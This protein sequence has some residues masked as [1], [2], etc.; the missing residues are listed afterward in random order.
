VQSPLEWE[1]LYVLPNLALPSDPN[2]GD[3][4]DWPTGL[5]LDSD[6][7][8]IVRNNDPRVDALRASNP[9]V[10]QILNSFKDEHG[11]DYDP[12]VLLIKASAPDS[13]RKD[14]NAIVAF[15]NAVAIAFLLRARA[16]AARGYGGNSPTWSDT[17]DFHPA[18]LGRQGRMVIQS[19]A[20]LGLVSDT[21]QLAFT[22]S[23]YVSLFR[24]RAWPDS[25]LYRCL[26]REWHRRYVRPARNDLFGRAL[27]R[28]L[29]V[30]YQA[31]AVGGTIQG[32]LHDYGMQVATWVSAMEILAWPARRHADLDG[33]LSLISGY[34]A[35]STL[36]QKRFR[37]RVRGQPR[38]LNAV[39]RSY[40][41]LYSARNSFLH[42]NPVSEATL[43]KKARRQSIGLPRL[44]ALV[45]RAALVAYLSRRYPREITTLRHIPE[46]AGEM[47][48]DLSYDEALAG[49]LG[50]ELRWR[51]LL[52][53]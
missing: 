36:A 1:F 47:M 2:T 25:Y 8:A 43:V 24:G 3:R 14:E 46:R 52:Q 39:Q 19:P 23:P 6:L 18:Q 41:Y 45:Y 7:I 40:T 22:Y 31:C 28:S 9:G 12:A 21:A 51:K 33:V 10:G 11:K 20:V 50:I 53:N 15:R 17:F 5:T 4:W 30:A 26:S 42:G 13:V 27:F 48:E 49:V 29:E 32:S 44:A 35:H 37:Y 34:E 38:Q 16:A